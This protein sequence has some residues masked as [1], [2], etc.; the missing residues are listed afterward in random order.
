MFVGPILDNENELIDSFRENN[1]YG[2]FSSF[3]TKSEKSE[4][5]SE[6][7]RKEQAHIYHKLLNT[8]LLFKNSNYD[9][10]RYIEKFVMH[11]IS[12]EPDVLKEFIHLMITQNDLFKLKSSQLLLKLFQIRYNW[13]KEKLKSLPQFSWVMQG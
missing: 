11:M 12:I 3:Y 2:H 4:S 1:H 10:Q 5:E 9:V 13:L 7:K 8:I 6:K